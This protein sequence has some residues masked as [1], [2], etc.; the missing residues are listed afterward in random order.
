MNQ[1]FTS[2]R[3]AKLGLALQSGDAVILFAKPEANLEKFTQDNN[4]LY[5]TGL[6]TPEAILLLLK[7]AENVT[8]MLFIE[9]GIPEREVW[10]GKKLTKAE[11]TEL[12]GITRVYYKD[13]FMDY[14]SV[15]APGLK[16]VY[17]NIGSRDLSK[18][19]SY[20][21]FALKPLSKRYPSVLIDD[22]S[23]VLTPLRKIKDDWEIAQLQK[24]IDITGK[25]ILDIMETATAG[26]MEYELEAILFYRMQRSG[27]KTWGFSPIIASGINA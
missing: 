9:R 15:Y 6:N 8:E 2:N 21:L 16:R 4:F 22:I 14:L 13:E 11:A 25:G 12:S 17:A 10:D 26:M 18:P 27:A 19:V 7:N 24:A 5:L 1:E 3:R 20:P 23:A